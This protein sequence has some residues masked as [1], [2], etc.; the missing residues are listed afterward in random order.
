MSYNPNMNENHDNNSLRAYAYVLTLV[1][2]LITLWEI[3]WAELG[4]GPMSFLYW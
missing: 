4:P 3:L 1:P 2:G